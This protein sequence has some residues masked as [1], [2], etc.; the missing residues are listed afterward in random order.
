MSQLHM[1]SKTSIVLLLLVQDILWLVV[2]LLW[3]GVWGFFWLVVAFV[4]VWGFFF[5]IISS[6][7]DSRFIFNF[8]LYFEEITK[9]EKTF[10]LIFFPTFHDSFD[11]FTTTYSVEVCKIIE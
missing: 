1:S 8:L 9:V 11:L 10:F 3:V 5:S 7:E 4:L 6:Q 2:G